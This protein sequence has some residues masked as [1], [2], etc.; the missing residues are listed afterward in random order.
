MPFP[1]RTT[2][3]SLL[4]AFAL[5][6]GPAFAERFLVY[7][8]TYTGEKSQGIYAYRF[9][10][11]SGAVEELGLVAETKNPT[12]LALHPNGKFLYAANE[13][14]GFQ[15]KPGG[16]VTGYA[17]DTATGKL[18]ELNQAST[19]G[20]GPCH[21][22][23]D[24]SGHQVLAANYGGGSVI[25]LPLAADGRLREPGVFIQHT[26]SSVN[27]ARQKEPHAHSINLSPDGRFAFAAD[28]GTDRIN[29]YKFDPAKGLVGP[30]SPD[31]P[32]QVPGSGPR[33]FA[34]H[35]SGR[36]A[37]VINEMLLTVTTFRYDAATGKL[38]AIDTVSTSPPGTTGPENS[39]AEIVVHPNGRFLYGSNRGHNT[40]AMFRVDTATGKLTPIGHQPTG[41]KTPRN[42]NIDPTG[43]WLWACN[44][45][46]HNITLHRVN[47]ET[48]AL[49]ATGQ[50]LKV[51][52][53]VCVKFLRVP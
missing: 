27:P 24:R 3:L 10:A 44:Q 6:S 21:L 40:L 8:G 49:T 14:G 18:K 52:S 51:G 15:G 7:V 43:R 2:L 34:F 19:G 4:F 28:L 13:I 38:T 9:D 45:D 16:S 26:G 20:D 30:A 12:F 33:H 31:S 17:I 5:P 22:I 32:Q 48:G 29:V 36:F 1:R 42:F 39:T 50:D 25:S 47:P 11:D 41:G 35:P 53:P 46:S 23:V 37:Y